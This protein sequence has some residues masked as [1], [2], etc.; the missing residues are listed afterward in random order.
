MKII[1][2]LTIFTLIFSNNCL[3]QTK[4][5]TEDFIKKYLEAYP[6][7]NGADLEK[8]EITIKNTDKFGYC[9]FYVNKIPY[10][11]HFVYRFEPKDIQSIVIDKNTL[12]SSVILRVK[13]KQNKYVAW[14]ILGSGDMQYQNDLE[15]MVGSSSKS[16]QIPERLKKAIEHLS[17]ITGGSITVDKF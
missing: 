3:S 10:L 8:T 6:Q 5:E 12:E 7:N 13:L 14:M 9:F 16:D 15:I 2:F 4:T 1:T 17:N 11:G